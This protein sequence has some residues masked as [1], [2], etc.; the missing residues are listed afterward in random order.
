MYIFSSFNHS[1]W[2][3]LRGDNKRPASFKDS[4]L[5]TITIKPATPETVNTPATTNGLTIVDAI[6]TELITL[7]LNQIAIAS[8]FSVPALIKHWLAAS[9]FDIV[10]TWLF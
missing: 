7:P 1:L 6:K 5:L 4:L 2:S 10:S 3:R 9:T 8:F